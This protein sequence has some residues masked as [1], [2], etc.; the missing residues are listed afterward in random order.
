[1]LEALSDPVRRFFDSGG[2]DD[3]G[4]APAETDLSAIADAFFCFNLLEDF[5]EETPRLNAGV[6]LSCVL[7]FDVFALDVLARVF[8]CVSA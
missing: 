5:F 2:T 7:V 3:L 6:V 1:M 8:L 4:L